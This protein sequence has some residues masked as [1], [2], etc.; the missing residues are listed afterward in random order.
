MYFTYEECFSAV[1]KNGLSLQFIPKKYK[2][3]EL[4]FEACEKNPEALP[5]IPKKWREMIYKY[6]EKRDLELWYREGIDKELFDK[7]L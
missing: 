4:C 2:T 5:F 3:K 6:F 1:Q 7:Y